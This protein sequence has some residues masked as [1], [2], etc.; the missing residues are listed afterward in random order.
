MSEIS[1]ETVVKSR[2]SVRGFQNREVPQ[3][4]L[5]KVFDLARW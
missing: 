2:R 1:F 4:V 5:N 3:E